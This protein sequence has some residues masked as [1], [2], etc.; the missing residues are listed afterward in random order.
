M[1]PVVE[2]ACKYA[3]VSREIIDN[4]DW[5]NLT[6]A[7]EPYE[8]K[9]PLLFWIGAVFYSFLGVS[10]ITFKLPVLL[11]SALGIYSTYRFARL[12]YR[13]R[14]GALAA[15]FYATS[16]GY[17]YYHNDIHTDTVL[18]NFVILAIWQLTAF[19]REKKWHQFL[20]G[21]IG[22]GLAM[23]SK[24]PI[25]L[26][27]PV[28]ALGTHLAATRRFREIFHVRWL[29]AAVLILIIISPALAGLYKEFGIGG[30]K[31]FFWTN[32]VGRVTGSLRSSNSGVF[33][34]FH[35]LI[36]MTSPWFVFVYAG[37]ILEIRKYV[38]KLFRKEK[39]DG[40]DELI[41][42]G[43][44]V[45]YFVVLTIASQKNPHYLMAV[46][47]LTMV[48]AAKWTLA[49]FDESRFPKLKR[50]LTVINHIFPFL[51]WPLVLV[52]LLLFFPEKRGWFWG[53]FIAGT[54]GFILAYIKMK[55]LRK[56]LAILLLAQ[57][58][59]FISLNTSILPSMLRYYSS[60]NACRVF[61]KQAE[62]GARLNS[63]RLR[64]WSIFYYS[65]SYGIWSRDDASL[66][67]IVAEKGSW[68]FTD[69]TGLD[70]LNNW[71]VPYT[72]KGEFNNRNLTGQSFKFLNP[73]TRSAHME[74]HYLVELGK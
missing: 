73:K 64:Y 72:L 65:K 48:L 3:Q 26:A 67:K 7:H 57:F 74:K 43:G 19:F 52:F 45:L 69:R 11:L 18:V 15:F 27:I 33:Y 25:G 35:N 55:G 42:I 53:L 21:S 8:Q 4:G 56:Q 60:F 20:L 24:G 30:I 62:A 37:L 50:V 63:Y 68:I 61:N 29:L 39:M 14:A 59:F 1:V 10:F 66:K 9:P 47:P 12:L 22:V 23:L 32:N 34:Y 31:F 44:I 2:N 17:F 58:V 6:I 51:I 49:I 28:F 36:L 46:L 54:I 70:V 71:N 41:N 16:L 40:S 5:L 38:L 13:N